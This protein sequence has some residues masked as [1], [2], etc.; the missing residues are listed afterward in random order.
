MTTYPQEDKLRRMAY[1]RGKKLV[2]YYPHSRWMKTH[3]PYAI[4]SV[5]N[6]TLLMW[7]LSFEQASEY[8]RKCDYL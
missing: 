6:N 3:G 2:K 1:R 5:P 4:A 7:G 8:I